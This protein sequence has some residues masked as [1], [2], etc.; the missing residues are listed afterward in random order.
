[1]INSRLKAEKDVDVMEKP[2]SN[3]RFGD[4]DADFRTQE[5]RKQGV[6]VKLPPQSLQI[7]QMLLERP[8][9]LV[10]RDELRQALWPGDTFVDF[11]HG[12]NN[13]IKR[14]RDA[15][16][17]SADTPSYIET[18]PRL[19]YRFIGSID[20]S[21]V[22]PAA[23][24]PSAAGEEVARPAIWKWGFFLWPLALALVLAGIA[25]WRFFPPLT[26]IAG[27]QTLPSFSPDGS[28]VTFTLTNASKKGNGL[29]TALVGGDKL[30]QLTDGP[31]DCCSAWSPDGQAVAF[32]RNSEK[33]FDINTVSPLG[34]TPQRVY[35]RSQGERQSFTH[36]DQLLAWSPD[37]TMLAFSEANAEGR[38]AITLLSLADHSTRHLTSPPVE[39]FDSQPAFSPDGK[40]MAFV[41]TSGPGE[42]DDLFLVPIEGGG[43]RRLTFDN[44][45]IYGS[46]AWTEDGS[47][48]V[49]S[50]ARA[51]LQGLWRLPVSGG[52]PR[53][54]A[55]AGTD[56]YYPAIATKV[57]RLAYM[58]GISNHNVWQLALKDRT[59]A[60]GKA[61]ML[62]A[63]QGYAYHPQ[64]SP[65]GT[66]IAFESNRS[67]YPGIWVCNRDGSDPVQITSMP[68]L[69]GTPRWSPDSRSLAFDFRPKEHSE[70][71]VV[72]VP[73]GTPRQIT[74]MPGTNNVVPSWSRNG[75]WVYFVSKGGGADFQVW[76]VP[77]RGGRAVQMTK[78]GGFAPLEADDGFLYFTKSYDIPGIWKVPS[79]GGTETPVLNASDAPHWP[80][81]AVVPGGMYFINSRSSPKPILEFFDFATGRRTSISALDGEPQGL[82]V[83]PDQKFILYSQSGQDSQVIVV[84]K[85]FR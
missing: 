81:W 41:R 37:G 63:A 82:A 17:D 5:L 31:G 74:T 26:G 52:D 16:G 79:S 84:V 8:G 1:V 3:L 83:S 69:A 71:Y 45:A 13:S 44:R 15:L 59:H 22:A 39:H 35:A 21:P 18:L 75:Q 46:P 27:R 19:G 2:G 70:I 78:K 14:I 48:L 64:F 85:N 7:L 54:V 65:D 10:T 28:Q 32:S 67:G 76:K 57:H 12:V 24:M 11:D 6:R 66:K 29:Y 42:V 25:V 60:Q 68:G 23:V 55:E 4:F 34:G 58:R 51:G 80:D 20:E 43:P 33:G 50:S 77:I 40:R 61:S 38:P 9:E 49:F 47:D 53:P 73:G 36:R 72:E 62:I 56:A 30:L